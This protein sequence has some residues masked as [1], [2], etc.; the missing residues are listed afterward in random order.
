MTICMGDELAALTSHF[1][2]VCFA[3]V[4]TL[5]AWVTHRFKAFEPWAQGRNQALF[6]A[7]ASNSSGAADAAIA[8]LVQPWLGLVASMGVPYFQRM[9]VD[10]CYAQQAAWWSTM[11]LNDAIR[12]F[13]KTT[14]T[15]LRAATTCGPMGVGESL[16]TFAVNPRR[17]AQSR[18]AR[19]DMTLDTS[20]STSRG[21]RLRAP[22]AHS[23]SRPNAQRI[24]AT[25][26]GH[27]SQ[28]GN[29]RLIT[30]HTA[31]E[32]KRATFNVGGSRMSPTAN[33]LTIRRFDGR[34]RHASE[35]ASATR[36]D[37]GGS[38]PCIAILGIGHTHRGTGRLERLLLSRSVARRADLSGGI[39]SV[40]S[41][42]IS[43]P[44]GKRWGKSSRKMARDS[45]LAA[46]A[47]RR[48]TSSRGLHAAEMK[49][50]KRFK[51]HRREHAQDSPFVFGFEYTHFF[52]TMQPRPPY[53]MLATSGEFCIS[54]AQNVSDCESVQF[55]SGMAHH[56]PGSEH[57]LLLSY[58]I[59]D[60]EAK[61]AKMPMSSVWSMLMPLDGE[62]DSCEVL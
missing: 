12:R 14:A 62:H 6:T 5:R 29:I 11:P 39:S 46:V 48:R 33:L 56:P 25:I 10:Q 19:A 55:V 43:G 58:G 7:P 27:P 32:R 54:S 61:V 15:R 23:I 57:A 35:K 9:R 49:Q 40:D 13:G 22:L 24:P 47:G 8:L 30:N 3:G 42:F 45:A 20:T 36:P 34:R 17:W 38:S 26:D 37:G 31:F 51:Q 16:D 44:R 18:A 59:N 28:F 52:Y 1:A 21:Q 41:T 53:R 4:H 60:C 50:W 2:C